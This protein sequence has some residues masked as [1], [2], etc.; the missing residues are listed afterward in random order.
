MTLG[1]PFK[2][3]F[4]LGEFGFDLVEIELLVVLTVRVAHD[5]TSVGGFVLDDAHR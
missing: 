4:N 1:E 2:H 3:Q 5:V